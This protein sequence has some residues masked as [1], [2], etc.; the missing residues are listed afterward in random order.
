MT[1]INVELYKYE[2]FDKNGYTRG[3]LQLLCYGKDCNN[4]LIMAI[5]RIAMKR[6]PTYAFTKELIK[7]DKI[8]KE[9]GYTDPVA[10]TYDMIRDHIKNIPIVNIDPNI[11]YL[12]EK[13]WKDVN[14]LDKDREKHENEKKINMYIDCKNDTNDII[15]VLTSDMKIYIDDK[16]V[17]NLYNSKYPFWI[18]SLKPKEAFKCSMIPMLSIGYRNKGSQW[19][20]APNGWFDQDTIKDKTI[21]HLEGT[22]CYD[23]ISLMS[24]TLEYFI[25]RLSYIK[26]EIERQYK[27]IE[28]DNEEFNIVIV[29][30]DHT[31][32]E[33]IAYE[34]QLHKNI[35]YASNS[36]P[37]HLIRSITIKVISLHKDKMMDYISESIDNL[38]IKINVF[39]EK[40]ED[41]KE[42]TKSVKEPTKSI[43]EPTK[44]VKE[45]TKSIKEPII[46]TTKSKSKKT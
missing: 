43:K 33:V 3:H 10:H 36:R 46:T 31:F 19:D 12:N 17:S 40:F 13:Y 18:T 15:H 5:I 4:Q 25:L 42:P 24:R 41:I 34:L 30:E 37:D 22:L 45:S 28:I 21:L 1:D 29:D 23:E 38:I 20:S 9:T 39:K 27:L 8:K 11:S 26:N 7:I 44:S 32:G 2:P 14:F 35:K 16:E 6:I